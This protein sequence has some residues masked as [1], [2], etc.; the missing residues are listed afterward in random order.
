MWRLVQRGILSCSQGTESGGD[1]RRDVE[2]SGTQE[3][4]VGEGVEGAEAAGSILDDADDAI[5]AFRHRVGQARVD[6]GE[7]AIGVFV[8][9]LAPLFLADLVDGVVE[10]FDDM[11]P[12]QDQLGVGTV[13]LDGP[14]HEGLADVAAGPVDL[15]LLVVAEVCRK[16]R[17]MVSRAFP[18]ATQ[19]TQ[20]RS[21][22]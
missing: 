2:V 15:R 20:A 19:T 6:E 5:G 11:E 9:G 7:D 14:P 18:R 3:D 22:S 13:R 1:P 21:R 16:N 10:R 12:I 4:D 8:H 17:S